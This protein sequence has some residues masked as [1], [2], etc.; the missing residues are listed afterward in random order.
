MMTLDAAR[1]PTDE[2]GVA[3]PVI[4]APDNL[5]DFF[6]GSGYP[7]TLF[8]GRDGTVLTDP[9]I[10]AQVAR[11]KTIMNELLRQMK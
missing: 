10:G 1:N 5:N 2:F 6:R 7:T 4:L 11:Y 9:V 3:Y 8:I